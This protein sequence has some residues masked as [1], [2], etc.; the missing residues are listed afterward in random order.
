MT[1]FKVEKIR[2]EAD[3]VKVWAGT[4]PRHRNWPVVYVL[5]GPGPEQVQSIKARVY[6]GE[7]VN[8]ESRMRQH[9]ASPSKAGLVSAR[10]VV[11][12]TF[13]KSVCL[14]L[15][16]HLIRW[17]A[18]DGKFVVMNGNEGVI[19][20]AYFERP[21]Y[22]DAFRSI[23]EELRAEGLFE[24]SIPEIENSDLFKLSPFK[25]LTSDQAI[26]VMDI[27]EGLF[28]DLERG[29]DSTSVVRGAPG[30]GKTVVAVFLMKLLAD[31][32]DYRDGD[33]VDPDSMFSEFFVTDIAEQLSGLRMGLVV[34]QQ[35]LRN[36]IK[37][38]FRKTPNLSPDMVVTPF[39]VG[40][41]PLGYD[42]L[43]VDETHR[44]NQRANQPAARLNKLFTDIN[45]ELFGQDD[46]LK[47]QLDWIT[48]RSKH[49]IL[50]LDEAQAVRPA[51]LPPSV[52]DDVLA[53]ARATGR[54]YLLETQMRVRAGADYVGFVGDLLRGQAPE[55]APDLGDY[56]LR[57]FEDFGLMREEIRRRGQEHGLARL[58]AGYAWKWE[59]R[60]GSA[61]HDIELDGIGLPWNRTDKDWIN[62]PTS[63]DEVGSIH[64]VQGYDLN[65]A[66]VIIGNDLRL[67]PHSGQV[68]F[69]RESYFDKKGKE[70]L[71]QLGRKITDDE[72]REFVINIYRVLLTR[73]I[74]G[75]YVYVCDPALRAYVKSRIGA[76]PGR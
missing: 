6:V 45:I 74:L 40:R 63:I 57:F 65:Y 59:S 28:E 25:A 53:Q 44:L 13:N 69:H 48:A 7:T 68:R 10:V 42:L 64:T 38:V 29:E 24:R 39:E 22:R 54:H 16:A 66:G 26:A 41:D 18:G 61:A 17:L 71:K 37:A 3:H 8:A 9:L 27:L 14:D 67:D 47:T 46:L 70:N 32:R 5:D 15:E 55:G 23:F 49:R 43:I 35:S 51:D 21:R 19:D 56:D 12:E 60:N 73:G 62:S 20:S 75:T 52:V 58:V 1:A 31:I 36:T 4:D 11:D 2:F 33:D 50:L 76:L 72:L 30:T 34:P